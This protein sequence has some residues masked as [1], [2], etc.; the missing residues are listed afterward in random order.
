MALHFIVDLHLLNG[1]LP[2]RSVFFLSIQVFNFFYLYLI[3]QSS[4]IRFF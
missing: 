4:T 3:A 2:I 1:R